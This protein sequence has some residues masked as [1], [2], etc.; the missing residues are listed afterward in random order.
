MLTYVKE[1]RHKYLTTILECL[2][3]SL[4]R[5]KRYNI[6]FAIS[7]CLCEDG[8]SLIPFMEHIRQTDIFLVL[9]KNLCVIVFDAILEDA[10]IKAAEN[11]ENIYQMRYFSKK[12]FFSVVTSCHEDFNNNGTKLIHALFDLLEYALENHKDNEV[13]DN[14]GSLV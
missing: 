13:V 3:D 11:L 12:I 9:E 1:K 2:D 10:A 4:Y 8:V 5:K 6:N 14:F 7:I